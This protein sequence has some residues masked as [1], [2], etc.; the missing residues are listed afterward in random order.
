M[1][2]IVADPVHA[3]P[4]SEDEFAERVMRLP[5]DLL[6]LVPPDDAPAVEPLP[7]L[8]AGH[9][10]FGSFNHPGKL[11]ATTLRLWA[12]V[13]DRVSGARL[14]VRSMMLEDRAG[15]DHLRARLAAAGIDPARVEFAGNVPYR[16]VLAS[17]NRVDV[18][19]DTTPYSGTMT[20]LEA[21]WMGVPVVALAG[22]RMAARQSAAHLTAAGLADMVARDGDGYV[23]L[24]RALAAD[25][26]GLAGLRAGMRERLQGSAVCDVAGFTR[27]LEGAYRAMWRDWCAAMG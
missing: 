16:E 24:A 4:G 19:L 3:P 9:I 27:A 5:N 21:L 14:L 2:W 23:D 10:T 1:D 17:Y 18:A 22:D 6:C 25:T 7:C 15:H 8:A 26:E 20:T 13:L 12:R 11:S